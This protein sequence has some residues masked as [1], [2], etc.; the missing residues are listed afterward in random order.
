MVS[1]DDNTL[2]AS[3]RVEAE[4]AKERARESVSDEVE[5]ERKHEELGVVAL[6][7]SDGNQ[8]SFVRD[9]IERRA[10]ERISH[11]A[12][13]EP[14]PHLGPIFFFLSTLCVGER[15][16]ERTN[17]C[18]VGTTAYPFSPFFQ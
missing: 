15:T 16:N 2:R 10:A 17:G 5:E 11:S 4:R 9:R 1:P 3:K 18:Q 6:C 13:C 8:R 14:R 7:T 12:R